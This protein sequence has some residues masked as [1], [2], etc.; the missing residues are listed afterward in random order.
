MSF[1][2]SS[3]FTEGAG[4]VSDSLAAAQKSLDVPIWDIIVESNS[5]FIL[6][7]LFLMSIYAIYIFVE[8]FMAL[9]KADNDEKQFMLQIKDYVQDGKL[10]SA[11][12]LCKTTDNPIARMVE[13]GVSRIGKPMNDI[14]VSIENVGKL[15]IYKLENKLSSLAT[16]SGVAPMIGFLGTVL[17]MIKV[18]FD[19]KETGVT[20]D[21][22]QTLSGGIMMAMVTTVAGLIVG[23]MAYV[24]YNFLVARVSKAVQNMESTSIDFI[25]I[26][27]EPGK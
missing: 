18:F 25:D 13:K 7:P 26:L 11:K 5:W 1:S 16:I 12:S 19:L 8:R 23:I 4:S 17:G 24:M 20:G 10:G 14:A 6:I 2:L 22:L 3:K 21:F 9:K 27:E 15:E